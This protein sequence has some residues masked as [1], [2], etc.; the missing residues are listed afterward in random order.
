MYC[1]NHE[2]SQQDKIV[3]LN[4]WGNPKGCLGGGNPKVLL[5]CIIIG[6]LDVV[7]YFLPDR[8]VRV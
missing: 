7:Q 2:Y 4:G 3:G 8:F 5:F 1:I 6:E